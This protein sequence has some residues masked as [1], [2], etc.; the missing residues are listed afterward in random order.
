M[1]ER[2]TGSMGCNGGGVDWQL[3][4][5]IDVLLHQRQGYGRKKPL[6]R[7]YFYICTDMIRLNVAMI[8]HIAIS[9]QI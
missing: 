4:N 6:P 9:L 5:L 7:H 8:W 2:P 3:E 1:V